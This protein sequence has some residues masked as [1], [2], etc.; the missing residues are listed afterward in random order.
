MINAS[1][2]SN[3]TLTVII[4][5]VIYNG[6]SDQPQWVQLVNAYSRGD[7]AAMKEL[8]CM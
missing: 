8:F 3:N 4:D 5:G 6:T 7:E 1:T 2:L